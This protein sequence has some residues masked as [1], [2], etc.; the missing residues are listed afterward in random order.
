MVN[1]ASL[2]C[3]DIES[4]ALYDCQF[5]TYAISGLSHQAS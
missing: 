2:D 4:M 3:V 1:K 5:F